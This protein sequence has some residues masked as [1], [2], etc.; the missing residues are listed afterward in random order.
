MLLFQEKA[1]MVV[2]PKSHWL[3]ACSPYGV[4]FNNLYVNVFRH[5]LIA[6]ISTG[7]DLRNNHK[8]KCEEA[9]ITGKDCST[10]VDVQLS[11]AI[12]GGQH[13]S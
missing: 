2:F 4:L 7:I 11:V 8:R 6:F 13:G 5:I 3:L 12:Q 9:G 10:L 1:I